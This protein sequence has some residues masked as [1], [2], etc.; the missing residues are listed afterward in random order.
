MIRPEIAKKV[1]DFT[2]K[3]TGTGIVT[4]K[5]PPMPTGK[6]QIKE[7]LTMM[8]VRITD[9]EIGEMEKAFK[10]N[11]DIPINAGN[12]QFALDQLRGK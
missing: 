9:L 1:V 11:S 8:K 4:K 7:I 6:S 12:I 3:N 10:E 5:I 2:V